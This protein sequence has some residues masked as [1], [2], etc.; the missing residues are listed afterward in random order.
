M[1]CFPELAHRLF[2]PQP[3]HPLLQTEELLAGLHI[4]TRSVQKGDQVP[5]SY[6]PPDVKS[7]V[8]TPSI[9]KCRSFRLF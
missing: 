8:H 9:S 5:T 3:I 1:D 2:Q 6:N 4:K 7:F